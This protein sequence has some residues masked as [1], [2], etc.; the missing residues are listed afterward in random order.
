MAGILSMLRQGAGLTTLQTIF[1]KADYSQRLYG[2]IRLEAMRKN[3]SK[4]KI[5]N[6]L[7]R[8]PDPRFFTSHSLKYAVAVE[9]GNYSTTQRQFELQQLLHFKQ[10]GIPISDR[11][12][13]QAAFITNKAEVISE[14]QEAAQQQQQQQQQQSQREAQNDSATNIG[15]YARARSDLAQE[16]DRMA[17]AQERLAKIDELQSNAASK[18]A[19][20]DLNLVKMMIN[21]EDMDLANFKASFEMAEAIKLQNK[22][23]NS[24]PQVVGANYG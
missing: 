14:M 17:Q 9:E 23:G 19:E 2:K 4:G 18:R 1:D 6:I 8:D 20:A 5:R 3:F 21:L 11:S 12:I 16:K 7:G 15:K 13:V 24:S 10:I 22:E